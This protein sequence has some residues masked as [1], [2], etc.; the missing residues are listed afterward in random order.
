MRKIRAGVATI[1]LLLT[2]AFAASAQAG[3]QGYAAAAHVEVRPHLTIY[4][5]ANGATVTSSPLTVTGTAGGGS[6]VRSVTVNGVT[7]TLSGSNWT[8]TVPLTHGQNTLTAT[9]T[10]TDGSTSTASVTVTYTGPTH[11]T[12]P[13][14][15]LVSKR[16]NGKAVLVKLACAA[17]DSNCAGKITLR[18]TETVVRHHKKRM[19]TL[20]LASKY[21]SIGSGGTATVKAALSRTG[22]K[23]LKARGKLA[24][25][26]AV[27][28]TQANG[29]ATT[30]ATFKL[31]LK[32]PA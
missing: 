9:M 17:S 11:L 21:Y 31:T 20:V 23:L 8:A 1:S 4:S 24:T 29:H 6:G 16:F 30:A 18:Y 3:G 27:T 19:I 15:T 22:R 26:G 7:A 28:V 32:Q 10:T 2:F 13:Y 5:P 25:K 12:P 14:V